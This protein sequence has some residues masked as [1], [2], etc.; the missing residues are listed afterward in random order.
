LERNKEFL[1]KSAA[2]ANLM[3]L[4][5]QLRKCCNHPYLIKGVEENLTKECL[6][7]EDVVNKM[8]NVS[9][10]FVFVDKLLSRLK[11]TG[12]RVLIFSQM[13]RLLDLLAEYLDARGSFL[14]P[15]TTRI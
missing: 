6:T 12:K 11:E 7:K 1:T 15:I 2:I 14:I 4:M 3:N 5:M 9:S 8:V 13:V 10:K